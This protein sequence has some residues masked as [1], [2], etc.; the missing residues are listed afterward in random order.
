MRLL[1]TGGSGS[2]DM[3]PGTSELHYYLR[4]GGISQCH[5]L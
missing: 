5:V 3:T 1:V 4:E 2:P